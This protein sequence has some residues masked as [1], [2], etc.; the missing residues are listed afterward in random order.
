MGGYMSNPSNEKL[1]IY[2]FGG[3]EDF[4]K[5]CFYE[6][7][8]NSYNTRQNPED[9]LPEKE[10]PKQYNFQN[11]DFYNLIDKGN[12]IDQT[13]FNA[14]LNDIRSQMQNKQQYNC[15][16]IFFDNYNY[17]EKL[18]MIYSSLPNVY[19]PIV[20]L[21]FNNDIKNYKNI[22]KINKYFEITFYTKD[23]YTEI[24]KKINS[25]YNY[26]FNIGDNGLIDFIQILNNFTL[27]NKKNEKKENESI[28]KIYKATFNIL[29]IGKTGCGKSTLINLLLNKKRAR[30]GIGYS[31]TKFYSQYAHEKYPINFTDTIGFEDNKSLEKMEKFLHSCNEFFNEGKGKY[32]LIFYLINAGNERTLTKKELDLIYYI[33]N[34]LNLPIFYICTHSKTEEASQEFKEAVKISLIQYFSKKNEEETHKSNNRNT[35]DKTE[36]NNPNTEDKTEINNPNTEDKTEINNQ[37]SKEKIYPILEEKTESI[38]SILEET[39]RIYCCHLVNE[40]DGKYKRFG[41]K[42]ILDEIKNLFT[43]QIEKIKKF[44]KDFIKKPTEEIK[45]N[46]NF[47]TNK[48][49]ENE[50]VEPPLNILRSLEK[51]NSFIEYLKKLSMNIWNKYNKKFSDI[52]KNKF[53]LDSI[54]ETMENI[55]KGLKNHLAFEL[56]IDPSKFDDSSNQQTNPSSINNIKSQDSS[57]SFFPKSVEDKEKEEKIVSLQSGIKRVKKIINDEL[58]KRKD[59]IYPYMSEVIHNYEEAINSLE[60]IKKYIPE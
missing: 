36:I 24:D 5:L 13:K 35:E 12:K 38:N 14:L 8:N 6:A 34:D 20:I 32:H 56:D 33:R 57:W 17:I 49:T 52:E 11:S 37:N 55:L 50:A 29:V 4:R 28:I 15:I 27:K 54:I 46:K 18:N 23:N 25:V 58:E 40:K 53:N 48:S 51:T 43:P 30:E 19:K 21:A 41:I 47:Q 7:N 42:K 31:I 9:K 3:S 26:Y 59:D 60:E 44:E 39:T 45:K 16:L 10:K 22:S 1:N 2:I